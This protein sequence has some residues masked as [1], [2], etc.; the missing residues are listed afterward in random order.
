M[1]IIKTPWKTKF[2]ELVRNSK[3][4][5]KIT[6][7]F[8]KEDICQ[9]MIN[10]KKPF[11]KVQLLT[12]FKLNCVY[13]G[14]IDVAALNQIISACGDVRSY[15][16]LHSKIYIFDNTQAVITSGNLTTGGMIRNFEYGLLLENDDIVKYVTED[17]DRLFDDDNSGKITAE[18]LMTVE[19]IIKKLP[20]PEYR[21]G[22]FSF[23]SEP[24]RNLDILQTNLSPILESLSG[25][26]RAIFECADR[27]SDD[28]FTLRDLEKFEADLS[29]QFPRNRHI[30]EKI[31]QQLQQLRD[32][33]LIEFLGAGKY[34]KLW[35]SS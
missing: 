1:K 15:P 21:I 10:A 14:M 3:K 35:K 30:P 23:A 28:V 6:A 24:E 8:V 12:S 2:L 5:I 33:G 29:R 4:S 11:V 18:H 9:E 26:R 13:L 22:D 16:N 20:P 32:L 31:R 25:W 34:R 7:P 27:I 17:F 19:S